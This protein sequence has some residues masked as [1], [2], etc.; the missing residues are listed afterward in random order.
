[1]HIVSILN[2]FQYLYKPTSWSIKVQKH[3]ESYNSQSFNFEARNWLSPPPPF[4]G[5]WKQNVDRKQQQLTSKWPPLCKISRLAD[6]LTP[7]NPQKKKH[8][9]LTTP[10]LN[11]RP[12][13]QNPEAILT[14]LNT[15][16]ALS[17]DLRKNRRIIGAF[18]SEMEA[19]LLR[20]SEPRANWA[21]EEVPGGETVMNGCEC[22]SSSCTSTSFRH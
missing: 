14:N 15:W 3:K 18:K 1:M 21:G 5:V 10:H 19:E 17:S 16:N 2:W 13:N 4:S 12:K 22:Y 9:K 11:K 8:K 7:P 6:T 20:V